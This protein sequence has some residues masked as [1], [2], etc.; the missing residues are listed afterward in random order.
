MVL[1][2]TRGDVWGGMNL[3]V[4]RNV[5]RKGIGTR[6]LK[7]A[8][9]LARQRGQGVRMGLSDEI[10]AAAALTLVDLLDREEVHRALRIALKVPREAWEVFDR[11]FDEHWGGAPRSKSTLSRHRALREQRA[12]AQWK[13]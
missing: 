11:L 13:W 4:S 5:Q 7:K 6:L 9:T 12:P 10:D 8:R 2:E 1:M 3:A